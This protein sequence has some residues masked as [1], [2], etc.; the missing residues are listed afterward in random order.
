MICKRCQGEVP[1]NQRFCP[2]CGALQPMI[3]PECGAES[4]P[5]SKVCSQ[6]GKKLPAPEREAPPEPPKRKK[7]SAGSI[8]AMVAVVLGALVLLGAALLYLKDTLQSVGNPASLQSQVQDAAPEDPEPQDAEPEETEPQDVEPE[9]TEPQDAEPEAT[10]P[11]DAE[12]EETEPQDAEPEATEPQDAEPE[13]TEPEAT[14]PQETAPV[15]A[16]QGIFPDSS[17][18]LLTQADVAGLS[19][20]EL[21]LARNEIYARHGRR[22]T[23]QELQAYF[24]GCSWYQGT[25]APADFDEGVFN[26]V[27]LANIAFLKAAE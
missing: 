4:R 16:G 23:N 11:Q 18:R 8:A 21:Q 3:C 10:E 27:E 25:I 5:G 9:E 17:E 14:E 19:A 7:R 12:P 22:F 15:E 26:D 2:T 13:E 6:C 20:W 24:D 1:D